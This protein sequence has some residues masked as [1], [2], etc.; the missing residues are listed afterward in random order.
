MTYRYR[1]ELRMQSAERWRAREA[2]TGVD[3]GLV[4]RLENEKVWYVAYLARPDRDG[5]SRLATLE[6]VRLELERYCRANPDEIDAGY[7]AILA[8]RG[9]ATSPEPVEMPAPELQG[10]ML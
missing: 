8:A 10:V 4:V 3:L 2:N 5:L 6:A 7:R 1:V 9:R